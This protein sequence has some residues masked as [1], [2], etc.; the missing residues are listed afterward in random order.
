MN[1]SHP[2]PNFRTNFKYNLCVN[3]NTK[4]NKKNI[5]HPNPNFRANFKTNYTNDIN[6]VNANAL[7]FTRFKPDKQFISSNT[8]K[9]VERPK[10]TKTYQV[11]TSNGKLKNVIK[12]K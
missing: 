3:L 1:K 8:L 10:I 6:R 2:N 12:L 7:S 4:D 9:K 5:K 11:L